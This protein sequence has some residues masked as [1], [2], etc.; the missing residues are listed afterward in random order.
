MKINFI[1]YENT[2][3]K[4]KEKLLVETAQIHNINISFIGRNS[5]IGESVPW[6]GFMDKLVTTKKYL[7]SIDSELVCVLDSRDILFAANE[8]KILD[9][10]L[11]IFSKDTV[12]FNGETNCYPDSSLAELHPMQ[13]KKYKYLNA[14]ACMG[15]RELLLTIYEDAIKLYKESGIPLN[16]PPEIA[17]KLLNET[18]TK[19]PTFSTFKNTS[20]QNINIGNGR[21]IQAGESFQSDIEQFN[22]NPLLKSLFT[23]G[24]IM[25][26]DNKDVKEKNWDLEISELE[27]S[28]KTNTDNISLYKDKEI[29]R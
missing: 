28:L 6:K 12:I 17:L 15:N 13:D 5:E 29:M 23:Q 1:S 4:F 10:F 27:K 2:V 26:I 19:K 14:G 16:L 21:I 18:N 22:K 8:S 9:T 11:N 7:E 20:D 25:Q 24:A 3:H